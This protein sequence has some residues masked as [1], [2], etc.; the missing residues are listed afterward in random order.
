MDYLGAIPDDDAL[1]RAVRSQNVVSITNPAARSAR[2]YEEIAR[3]LADGCEK[4]PGGF[5]L[6]G[7]FRSLIGRKEGR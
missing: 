4:A 2:A 5:S 7:L 6:G 3:S 1:E